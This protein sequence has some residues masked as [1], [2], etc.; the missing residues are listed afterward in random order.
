MSKLALKIEFGPH[1][2][3]GHG[4]VRL[5]ELIE[6]HGSIAAAG[7]AM[8]MSYRRAWQLVDTLNHGFA[9]PLVETQLGGSGGGGASLTPFGREAVAHF[10][11]MEHEAE[12]AIARRMAAL[13]RHVAPLPQGRMPAG[14][15]EE[16]EEE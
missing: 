10:R 8:G 3:L 13:E 12:Q 11:A 7:R 5:L 14:P 2:M 9:T 15:D 6:E 16:E 1:C 4:K